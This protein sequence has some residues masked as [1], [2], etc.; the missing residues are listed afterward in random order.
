[1][2]LYLLFIDNVFVLRPDAFDQCA[3]VSIAVHQEAGAYVVAWITY[4]RCPASESFSGG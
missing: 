2:P 3:I 1:M 4:R